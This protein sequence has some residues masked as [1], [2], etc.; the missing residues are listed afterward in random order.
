MRGA[1]LRSVVYVMWFRITPAHAGSSM[2]DHVCLYTAQDHP[3]AC[4][5]QVKAVGADSFWVGSPPRMR[6]AVDESGH[7]GGVVGITPA[8]AGSS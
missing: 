6:G 2:T 1:V 7:L 3:R 8:H 4:G 5:E